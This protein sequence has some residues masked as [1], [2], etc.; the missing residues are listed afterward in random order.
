MKKKFSHILF[1]LVLAALAPLHGHAQV[2]AGNDTIICSPG[3][4]TLTATVTPSNGTTSYS[5]TNVNYSPFPYSTGTVV[6]FP[7]NADDDVSA[8][9]PIGFNFCFFGNSYSQFYVGTNGWISFSPGQYVGGNASTPIPSGSFT[10]PRNCIMAAWEDWNMLF[11]GTVHYT[12][13]GAAP[14]R[15]LIVSWDQAAMFQCTNNL[16]TF[17]IICY[18]TSNAIDINILSKPACNTWF[19]GKAVEGLHDA[20]GTQAFTVPGRN[21]AQWNVTNDA[22]RFTPN[23]PPNP[24]TVNWYDLSNANVGTGNSV[25]VNVPATTTY[26]AI[27]NYSCSNLNDTDSVNVV[28][29][30]PAS[31]AGINLQCNGAGTGQAWVVTQVP[32]PYTFAWS[33]GGTTDTISNLPAGTY[34]V[35]VNYGPCSYQDS[36]VVTEPPAINTSTVNA[37]DTCGQAVGSAG[38]NVQG[39]NGPF[40]YQWSN[41]ATT[42]NILGLGS[43]TYTVVTT[44]ANGCTI[45][46]LVTVNDLPGPIAAYNADPTTVTLIE[47]NVHFTDASSG[48][49]SWSWDFGDGNTSASQN[50]VHAYTAEGTY[51]V[52]LVVTNQY[53]CSDTIT[54]IV[55]V[56]GFYTFYVPNAF[57]PNGW[58]PSENETFGPEFS[59]IDDDDY[60]FYVFDRWGNRV[61]ETHDFTERWNGRMHNGSGPVLEEDVYVYLFTFDD[62]K[63]DYHEVMGKVTL[64]GKT[65]K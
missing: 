55:T 41:G 3:N 28:V 23:G 26:Y 58:G 4:V 46:D 33:N 50:P 62:F 56:E 39:G 49:V 18:E 51:T 48:G 11:G 57:T 65:K 40:T 34:Y 29:G 14:F 27:V 25:S 10:V 63:G 44:D 21:S 6:N 53:G 15:R 37:P 45:A 32:G 16:G 8:P 30:I 31:T 5:V 43:G 42:A 54:G 36:V 47:P 12:T 24:Y 20:A 1:L 9:L 2:F 60:S 13:Q 35:T 52:T 38:V 61:F 22:Y 17:Q 7:S 59:G 64:L 19:N